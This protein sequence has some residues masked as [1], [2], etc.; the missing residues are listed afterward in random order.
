[1]NATR[2]VDYFHVSTDEVYFA[3]ICAKCSRPYNPENRSLAW[4][5]FANRAHG[6]LTQRGR[7]MLAWV[8]YPVLPQHI[9]LLPTDLINGV[10]P[11]G[12][13]QLQAEKERGMRDLIYTS[14]QGDELLFPANLAFEN[15]NAIAPGR[16]EDTFKAFQGKEGANPIGVYGAAW[17]DSGLH[18]ETFWLGWS[19]VAQYGWK[20]ATPAVKQHV[21]EF[22]TVFYGPGVNGMTEVYRSLQDQARFFDRSWD[23]VV[24]RVRGKA[25]GDSE[26]KGI[27]GTRYDRTLPAPGLPAGPILDFKR[28]WTGR[29]LR[30]VER[31][32][33]MAL[34]N[35]LLQHRIQ[36]NMGKAERNRYNL[37][38]F[39][40]LAEFVAH[41]ERLL[42]GLKS[43]EDTLDLARASEAK[44]NAKNALQQLLSASAQ[45]RKILRDRTATFEYLKNI[46]EKSRYPKGQEVGGR[47]FY[48]VMDDTKDHWADR[49]PDLTYMLAPEESIG[50]EKWDQQM[51][52]LIKEYARGHNLRIPDLPE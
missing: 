4:V 39:L 40:S 9:R 30:L 38:V 18:G 1:M 51:S 47:K 28:A 23:K 13:A 3:G 14:M 50:L 36:E 45:A 31:A 35:D 12:S 25:Y 7:K 48:H 21:A 49:R 19:V 41:Y 33:V 22:M 26:G 44:G 42:L 16:L 24:S 8:E 43:I 11:D 29:Y 27:G 15:E 46:W 10:M 34:E 5:E 20:P 6:F 17:D 2:G 32:K 37:E 52:A